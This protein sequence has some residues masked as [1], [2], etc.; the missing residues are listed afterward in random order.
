MGQAIAYLHILFIRMQNFAK[1]RIVPG[2]EF[3]T[4]FQIFDKHNYCPNKIE[5]FVK[6][7]PAIQAVKRHAS[8]AANSARTASGPILRAF[9]GASAQIPTVQESLNTSRQQLVEKQADRARLRLIAPIADLTLTATFPDSGEIVLPP[10]V[11]RYQF[12]A[13]VTVADG[14]VYGP[15]ETFLKTWRIKNSGEAPWTSGYELAFAHSDQMGA[16]DAIPLPPAGSGE[17]IDVSVTLK[18]PE[19]L[20]IFRS[21]WHPRDA[22]G[23]LFG[24]AMWAE[25][26]V[27][28]PEEVAVFDRY[29]FVEDVTI[30]DGSLMPAGAEIVKTWRVRNTGTTIW[31]KNFRIVFVSGTQMGGAFSALINKNVA[32][33]DTAEISVKLRAPAAPGTYHGNWALRNNK[34]ES[35]GPVICVQV[36]VAGDFPVADG[37]HWP[38]GNRENLTGWADKNPFLRRNAK[39]EYHPGADFNDTGW[40]D[41]DLGAP[42]YAVAD[43]IV[44][45]VGF[46]P[47]W[48]NL[49]LIEHRLQDGSQIWS[50]YA[51][52]RE[53]LVKK[54]DM[55]RRGQK[56]G[57][58]GKGDNDRYWAHL[59]F[60]IRRKDFHVASWQVHNPE[61]VKTNYHDP[62]TFILDHLAQ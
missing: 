53:V 37:F 6:K 3:R 15:G 43:G 44:T 2:D 47:V 56:I 10:P 5:L 19:E 60:E 24:R 62:I 30:P 23:N 21:Y 61:I 46:W 29:D 1:N 32:P 26:E 31:K 54:D 48:G 51:H 42:I 41:H 40:G 39:G 16:P 22:D 25:I 9:P 36:K 14:T 38:V 33:G 20:G 58:I 35:I 27:R 28:E 45:A 7:V 11:N 4:V 52:P 59:H 12:V 18:A 50:Q 13:D 55:V 17:E 49:I 57:T 34:G 8:V